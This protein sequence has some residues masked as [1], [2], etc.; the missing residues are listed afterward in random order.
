MATRKLAIT[1]T[2]SQTDDGGTAVLSLVNDSR[3]LDCGLI[4]RRDVD[5]TTGTTVDL[6]PTSV[7]AST[8]LRFKGVITYDSGTTAAN[9]YVLVEFTRTGPI[10]QDF[11]VGEDFSFIGDP[12]T[13]GV[14]FTNSTGSTIRIQ[15]SIYSL[16]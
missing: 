9:R 8:K 4:D 6:W 14:D 15:C 13:G 16:A 10:N 1:N 12:S 3:T 2:I 7:A 5:V 11:L